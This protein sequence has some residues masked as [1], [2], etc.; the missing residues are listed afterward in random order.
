MNASIHKNFFNPFCNSVNEITFKHSKS[1]TWFFWSNNSFL[2]WAHIL[3]SHNKNYLFFFFLVSFGT[4]LCCS[5]HGKHSQSYIC[6]N[7]TIAICIC[8]KFRFKLRANHALFNISF[9]ITKIDMLPTISRFSCSLTQDKLILSVMYSFSLYFFFFFEQLWRLVFSFILLIFIS[10]SSES[11]ACSY[12]CWLR[13]Y[14]Y[15]WAHRQS[16]FRLQCTRHWTPSLVRYVGISTSSNRAMAYSERSRRWRQ[17]RL[18]YSARL[19]CLNEFV[20]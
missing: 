9:I 19:H 6:F 17:E 13:S 20:S 1:I 16:R 2:F 3:L 7:T 18:S 5:F 14:R 11:T 15:I 8:Y 10:N 4:K 12:C